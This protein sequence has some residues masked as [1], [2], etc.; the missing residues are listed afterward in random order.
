VFERS[1]ACLT[2]RQAVR[3][4]ADLAALSRERGK[5]RHKPLKGRDRQR[6]NPDAVGVHHPIISLVARRRTRYSKGRT[7]LSEMHALVPGRSL[8]AEATTPCGWKEGIIG[9]LSDDEV[10]KSSGAV[11]PPPVERLS[12][13]KNLRAEEEEL[14]DLKRPTLLRRRRVRFP[15][16]TGVTSRLLTKRLL[17][18]GMRE[19]EV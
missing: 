18:K 19:K 2:K 7:L 4:D 9:E 3:N 14:A 5:N 11:L 10:G 17:P 8:L 16:P 6:E 12:I 13:E 15:L 1:A